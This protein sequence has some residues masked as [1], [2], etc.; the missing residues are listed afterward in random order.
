M[1]IL[2]DVDRTVWGKVKD[3]ATVK[4]GG[5]TILIQNEHNIKCKS[6]SE[7]NKISF[8]ATIKSYIQNGKEQQQ[9]ESRGQPR[10]QSTVAL[11]NRIGDTTRID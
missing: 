7:I 1:K 5:D 4:D 10:D 3:F 6:D 9:I 2:V 8:S 11:S